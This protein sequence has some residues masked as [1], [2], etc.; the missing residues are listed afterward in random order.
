LE[1]VDEWR[2][3]LDQERQAERSR[4]CHKPASPFPTFVDASHVPI[5]WRL[6]A[7]KG[8]EWIAETI[9]TE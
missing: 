3:R 2:G 6:V 5:Y 4:F 1:I 7:D 9:V 8:P